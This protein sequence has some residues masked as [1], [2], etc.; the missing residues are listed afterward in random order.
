FDI[1]AESIA[2]PGTPGGSSLDSI[3]SMK[4][5]T[6]WLERYLRKVK[7]DHPHAP[8]FALGR[9][10][11]AMMLAQSAFDIFKKTG[12]SPFHGLILLSPMFPH[13]P[14][15]PEWLSISRWELLRFAENQRI[16]YNLPM[17]DWMY[18]RH[19][20]IQLTTDLLRRLPLLTLVGESDV[21]Q[22]P[23]H[24]RAEYQQLHKRFINFN[25]CEISGGPHDLLCSSRKHRKPRLDTIHQIYQF[26][27]RLTPP[28]S[29]PKRH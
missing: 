24:E 19:R 11:S 10:A 7:N 22:V 23:L 5:F 1:T 12:K 18:D 14:D 8:I 2:L 16:S 15:H 28:S 20:E 9:S 21:E 25:Y 26:I 17:I 29:P 6:K 4:E 3:T 27:D 13:H